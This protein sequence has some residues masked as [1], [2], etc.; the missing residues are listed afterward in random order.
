[1]AKVDR[2]EKLALDEAYRLFHKTLEGDN[3]PEH[4]YSIVQS[5]KTVSKAVDAAG[6]GHFKL[7]V[8]LWQRIQR[9]LFDKLVTSYPAHL[10]VY[11]ENGQVLKPKE[12][13]SDYGVIE[14]HPEGLRRKDD[15]FRMGVNHLPINTRSRLE[16]VWS[17][18]G[19]STRADDF[20]GIEE[21]C[22]GGICTPKNFIIGDEILRIESLKGKEDAYAQWWDLFWQSYCTSSVREKHAMTMQ[23]NQLES[24]GV[25]L[26]LTR[27]PLN[28]VRRRRR[29]R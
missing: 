11:D 28:P 12:S 13:W 29:C 19:P 20:I 23:M 25:I 21:E 7:T 4:I 27:C 26:L 22:C 1:M 17:E 24:S 3:A 10:V 14:I 6:D 18:R 8:K 2:R 15:Y 5:L 16:K 9:A